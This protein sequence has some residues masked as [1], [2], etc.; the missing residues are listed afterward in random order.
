MLIYQN[1]L[2]LIHFFDFVI[3]FPHHSWGLSTEKFLLGDS[4]A[5]ISTHQLASEITLIIWRNWTTCQKKKTTTIIVTEEKR[6]VILA[7]NIIG[8]W[9]TQCHWEVWNSY[10][11]KKWQISIN[12][13]NMTFFCVLN[14][15]LSRALVLLEILINDSR[16]VTISF[17]KWF[18][19]WTE[20]CSE[21]G[22]KKN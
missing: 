2:Y 9:K 6:K 18:N 13:F 21:F 1:S 4:C 3:L 15:S 11:Q 8:I 12:I 16:A 19:L 14:T 22:A 20:C 10:H 7:E 17:S 5:F